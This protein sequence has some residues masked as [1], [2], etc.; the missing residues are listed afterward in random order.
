MK[1]KY[2]FISA[3]ATI[4]LATACGSSPKK[5]EEPTTQPAATEVVTPAVVEEVVLNGDPN[6]ASHI[7]ISK[8]TMT[9]K[10]YDSSNRVIFNFPIAVGKNYGNKQKPG[11]MKTPEG[12]FSVQQ[13]VNA[14]A[15]SHDFK[16]G[17]GVIQHAY[18]DWFI[19]LKTPGHS[20][21]GIHG[22]HDPN[23]IGTRATE[24]CIRLNN[25]NLNKLQ[26]L[27]YTGMKVT[28]LTSQRD[29]Q[30]DGLVAASEQGAPEVTPTPTPTEE[31]SAEEPKVEEKKTE[32]KK[33]EEPKKEEKK[34]EEKKAEPTPAPAA[35][36]G[37]II[38]VTL[39]SG[40]TLGHLAV[41]YNTS[42]KDIMELNGIEDATKV[43]AGQKLKVRQGAP[44]AEKKEAKSDPSGTYH[45]IQSG[46]TFGKL[47]KQYGTTSSEIQKLNPDVN[48][49]S[50]QINQKIRVK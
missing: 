27:V 33:A 11:D 8:E 46:D 22:T 2:L 35:A 24:G 36:V 44:K 18:G 26:P 32:E 40:Q 16:D 17:K 5:S 23:S 39:E 3:L 25:E 1:S 30:A 49:N 45:T 37:E 28:I 13:I 7:V 15:W 41:K 21:I 12:E 34:A 43:R 10:L 29:Q 9:L 47:A 38:E 14:S 6:K 42:S 31:K 50:L 19:R 20:G 4:I 48:P